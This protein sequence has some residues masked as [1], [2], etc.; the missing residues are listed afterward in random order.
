[1]L[2]IEKSRPL[3]VQVRVAALLEEKPRED[4]R[5]RD[6]SQKPY[7]HVE[8]TRIDDTRRVPVELVV[9]GQAVARKEIIADGRVTDIEFEFTP[10]ISSWVAVRI[11]PSSH[12]NPVFVEVDKKPIRASKRSA[13]WCLDAVDV[14][15]KSKEPRIRESE[16]AD[17]AAAYE[18]AREAYRRIIAESHE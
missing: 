15:W 13:Q 11:F 10:E 1:M 18:V 3:K 6:L 5:S 4:I 17:A 2:A 14:C 7:W 8:R 16:K 9:N 12:T